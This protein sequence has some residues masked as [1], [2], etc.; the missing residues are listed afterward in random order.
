MVINLKLIIWSCAS[1][2]KGGMTQINENLQFLSKKKT[3]FPAI[4]TH[5]FTKNIN[6]LEAFGA[7]HLCL[8]TEMI[9]NHKHVDMYN[10]SSVELVPYERTCTQGSTTQISASLPVL[11][12]GSCWEWISVRYPPTASTWGHMPQIAYHHSNLKTHESCCACSNT[13][14]KS[15][16]HDDSPWRASHTSRKYKIK[17]PLQYKGC[18]SFLQIPI[19]RNVVKHALS[20]SGWA[21]LPYQMTGFGY[22]TTSKEI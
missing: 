13:Q 15:R 7:I 22:N 1:I 8:N 10:N 5:I 20:P 11:P 9:I 19:S 16:G 6:K 17:G 18:K 14:V 2:H 3:K 21:G 12:T 4:D